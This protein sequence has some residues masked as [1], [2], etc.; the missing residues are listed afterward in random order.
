MN[1]A[2]VILN[3]LTYKDTIECVD[4]IL[5]MNY[6]NIDIIIV[7]NN[8]NN[9]SLQQINKKYNTYR[10][11]YILH[12]DLNLGFAKGNNVGYSFAKYN[13]NPDFIILLNNDTIINQKDFCEILIEH[14]KKNKFDIGGPTINTLKDSINQNPIPFKLNDKKSI[15]KD[16]IKCK[17]LELFCIFNLDLQIKK[18]NKKIKKN[19]NKNDYMLH[20]SCLIFSKK[21]IDNYEGLYPKTFLYGEENILKYISIRDNLKMVYINNVYIIHKED[22]TMDKIY[23]TEKNKRL[24]LYK[25]YIKSLKILYKLM[26]GEL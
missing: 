18:V 12:N 19:K 16:I 5:N 13:L 21:Y 1:V 15:L 14:Y 25:N 11:V 17:I 4:S 20:G 8:S 9:E 24:S 22:A 6:K 26:N 10:N 3:Y 23:K 7:D 2:F